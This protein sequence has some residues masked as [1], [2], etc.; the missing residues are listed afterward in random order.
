MEK[1]QDEMC[2]CGQQLHYSNPKKREM[3]EELIA[4]LGPLVEVSISRG[5]KL[6]V[7]RHYVALHG[8]DPQHYA[9]VAAKLGF[10]EVNQND[11]LGK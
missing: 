3:V 8:N 1:P 11:G 5:Q 6:R 7:P 9:E 10:Q 4:E 2:A